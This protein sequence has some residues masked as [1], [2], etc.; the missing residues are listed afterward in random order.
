[1]NLTSLVHGDQG[2]RRSLYSE[3]WGKNRPISQQQRDLFMSG[4][5]KKKSRF[6]VREWGVQS[7][8]KK[9]GCGLSD[10]QNASVRC[11]LAGGVGNGGQL[12]RVA[13]RKLSSKP[14]GDRFRRGR[15]LSRMQ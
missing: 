3:S 2:C 10:M 12:P 13:R 8:D 7:V 11:Q 15:D 4:K 5:S 6:L 1:M 14:R 9:A